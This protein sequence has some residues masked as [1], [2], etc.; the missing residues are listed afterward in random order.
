MDVAV[1]KLKDSK[2]EMKV[3]LPWEEWKGEIDHAAEELSKGTKI[4]GF[5]PGKAPRDVIEKRFGKGAVLAEAAEHAVGH[6]YAK[7]LAQE[8]VEAIGHPE[9]EIGKLAEGEAIEYT[10][11]A[12][13][14]PEVKIRSSW[15]DAAKKI[16][17]DF[18]KRKEGIDEQE[19]DNE[20]QRIAEMRAPLVAVDREAKMGD[21]VR[22]DFIVKQDGVVIEGGKSD[23]H[24]LVLGKGVFIPGFEEEIVGLKAGDEKTFTLVFPKEYHAAHLAGREAEFSVKVRAVEE[25]VLPVID[26]TFART[27]GSFDSLEKVKENIRKGMLQESKAKKA[28]EHRTALLDA[29]VERAE[30][31]YPQILV[32]E[33]ASR[34]VR[35]FESQV[36][37]MGLQFQEYLSQSNK[38]EDDLRKEWEPQAKKRLAAHLVIDAIAKEEDIDADSEAIEAEMNVALQYFKNVKDAE[39]NIDMAQLY[40]AVRGQIRSRKAFEFLEKF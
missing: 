26:D 8:K 2:V 39:K 15:K 7:A 13:V 1:K 20:I 16:N 30:L 22:I 6:S 11:I 27:L 24:A 4:A 14:M 28:E 10:A 23:D 34:M 36:Q 18:A 37:G 21:N 40:G 33:E 3:I 29:L 12:S 32:D 38:T 17:A 19:V 9:V 31:E 35:E 5:R 25:R